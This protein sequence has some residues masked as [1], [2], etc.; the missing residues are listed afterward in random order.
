MGIGA[1]AYHTLK[2][3]IKDKLGNETTKGRHEAV[4]Y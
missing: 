3:V 2:N 4:F 1:E